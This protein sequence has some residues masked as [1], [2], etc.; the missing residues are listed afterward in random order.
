M[1][2]WELWDVRRLR[3]RLALLLQPWYPAWQHID[4]REEAVCHYASIGS[5]RARL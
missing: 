4:F 2:D 3:S 5:Q 1:L